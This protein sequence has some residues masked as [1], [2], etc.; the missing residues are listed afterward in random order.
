[1]IFRF[2]KM[3]HELHFWAGTLIVIFTFIP[4]TLLFSELLAALFAFLIT[5]G[6]AIG[7]EL[8]D[9]HIKKTRFDWTDAKWTVIGAAIPMLIFVVANILRHY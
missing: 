8:Y 4:C 7:K 6:V 5:T 9:K 3:D 1:M 2:K